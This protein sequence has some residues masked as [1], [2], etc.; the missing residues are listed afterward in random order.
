MSSPKPYSSSAVV[1]ATIGWL[2][3]A[4]LSG[5]LAVS[6]Y[7]FELALPLWLVWV[8]VA[9]ALISFSIATVVPPQTRCRLAEWFQLASW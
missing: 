1:V 2:L 3:I 9:I 7:L 5:G 6:D 8:S 4:T